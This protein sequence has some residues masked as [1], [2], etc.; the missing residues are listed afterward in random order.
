MS[1]FYDY[2]MTGRI[3]NEAMAPGEMSPGMQYSQKLDRALKDISERATKK[4][5]TSPDEAM[6]MLKAAAYIAERMNS[7]LFMSL[8]HDHPLPSGGSYDHLGYK[9]PPSHMG[10]TGI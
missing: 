8:F 7:P 4:G 3:I 9:T 10:G 6:G 5:A 2:L 1:E